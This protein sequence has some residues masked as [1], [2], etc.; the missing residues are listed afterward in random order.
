M[1]I[2]RSL[3]DFT[4][5]TWTMPSGIGFYLDHFWTFTWT[6]S[7]PVIYIIYEDRRME[8]C[9]FSFSPPPLSTST[10]V[11]GRR[12]EHGIVSGWKSSSSS[13]STSEP[14]RPASGFASSWPTRNRYTC[15]GFAA[16][17]R[18]GATKPARNSIIKHRRGE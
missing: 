9:C 11:R 13:S 4:W 2:Y 7:G 17:C 16:Q 8:N 5:V 14:W 3:C 15:N 1:C 10:T 12:R 18:N 6:R